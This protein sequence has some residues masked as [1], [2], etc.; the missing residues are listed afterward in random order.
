MTILHGVHSENLASNS[1]GFA[2]STR[3][4]PWT[5]DPIS[6]YDLI[7]NID[8][9]IDSEIRSIIEKNVHEDLTWI[10][11]PKRK[12]GK[13]KSKTQQKIYVYAAK[14]K[15]KD[16]NNFLSD[17]DNLPE[18]EAFLFSH[19]HIR[20]LGGTNTGYTIK[21]VTDYIESKVDELERGQIIRKVKKVTHTLLG[22]NLLL[23]EWNTPDSYTDLKRVS[24]IMRPTRM[25]YSIKDEAEV[26]KKKA[27]QSVYDQY[28]YYWENLGYMYMGPK[29]KLSD[30]DLA[31]INTNSLIDEL[32]PK[33]LKKKLSKLVESEI[34]STLNFRNLVRKEKV[35]EKHLTKVQE[36]ID[37]C[38]DPLLRQEKIE[39]AIEQFIPQIIDLRQMKEGVLER[40]I[41]LADSPEVL[42]HA[43]KSGEM[44]RMDIPTLVAGSSPKKEKTHS[45]KLESRSRLRRG[46]KDKK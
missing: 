11:S 39:Q 3:K 9:V 14:F 16:L 2:P 20:L 35:Q 17:P 28:R 44:P 6:I 7:P 42:T 18:L 23:M 25:F 12:D 40:F 36:A 15:Y 1:E 5:P 46:R 43:L 26:K 31:T 45:L 19:F 8:N 27:L 13:F 29:A 37:R 22:H 41:T 33:I 4:Y 34:D 38:Q 30:E 32:T 10:N 24:Q 21:T